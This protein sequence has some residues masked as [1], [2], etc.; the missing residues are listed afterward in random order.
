MPPMFLWM[1]SKRCSN[2]TKLPQCW[3]PSICDTERLQ[4][5]CTAAARECQP[6]FHPRTGCERRTKAASAQATV[7]LEGIPVMKHASNAVLRQKGISV[8]DVMT[9]L[10]HPYSPKGIS[11]LDQGLSVGF[12]GDQIAP[13]SQTD[14]SKSCLC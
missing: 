11:C 1:Q 8:L 6:A 5:R 2:P 13:P 12:A 3:Q 9:F 10:I 7:K 14:S 4:R